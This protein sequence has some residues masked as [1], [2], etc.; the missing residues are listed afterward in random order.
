MNK[1]RQLSRELIGR[2]VTAICT[3]E[4]LA[5]Y[6]EIA[7]VIIGAVLVPGERAPYLITEEMVKRMKPGSVIIDIS[8]D[9]GGCVETT[10][11]M[12][13]DQPTFIQHGVVHYC[14]GNMT[15]NVPRTASRVLANAALP[16]LKA[17]AE[18]G[19]DGAIRGD[20][21]LARGVFLYEGKMVHA[22]LGDHFG[23]P[24]ENLNDLL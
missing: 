16:Y 11:P 6:S 22:G 18:R 21:A 23:I 2:P 5:R 12:T 13:L 10:R 19:L 15:S 8:V 3:E 4:R 17:L 20:P 24:T 1:L 9:Q 14:V 7:D